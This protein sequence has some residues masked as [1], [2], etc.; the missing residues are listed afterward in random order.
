MSVRDLCAIFS[1]MEQNVEDC[2]FQEVD[3]TDISL[4]KILEMLEQEDNNLDNN[5]DYNE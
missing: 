3:D 2:L 5:F 1:D 4:S